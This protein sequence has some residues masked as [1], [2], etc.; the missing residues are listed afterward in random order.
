MDGRENV[1]YDDADTD[2]AESHKS[3]CVSGWHAGM[4]AVSIPGDDPE[5]VCTMTT[6]IGL[7]LDSAKGE[8]GRTYCRDRGH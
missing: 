6:V 7:D 8:G 1:T 3:E 2:L 4:G 5:T